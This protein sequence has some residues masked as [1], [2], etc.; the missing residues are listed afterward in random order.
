[1]NII[2][3]EMARHFVNDLL[4]IA[5]FLCGNQPPQKNLPY[6]TISTVFIQLFIDAGAEAVIY[7]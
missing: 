1:M 3:D 7:L 5:G 6:D 4:K 2:I